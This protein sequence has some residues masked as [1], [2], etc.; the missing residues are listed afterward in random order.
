MTARYSPHFK[1][2]LHGF[3]LAVQKKF[4]KQVSFL[5][6]NVRHPSL[7][8]KKYLESEDVW[9]ARVDDNVRFYFR[10]EGDVYVLLDIIRH[11]K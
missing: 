5:L 10:V 8:A 11:P 9:Q 7:H 4:H 3:S 6:Q 2:N 1:R